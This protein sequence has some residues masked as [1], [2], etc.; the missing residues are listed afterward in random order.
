MLHS[1]IVNVM[2]K[3]AFHLTVTSQGKI[4]DNYVSI[5]NFIDNTTTDKGLNTQVEFSKFFFFF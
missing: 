5:H 3:I 2:A 1:V 4:R